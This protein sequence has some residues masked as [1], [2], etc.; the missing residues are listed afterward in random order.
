[1]VR[2]ADD[3]G[4]VRAETTHAIRTIT[5]DSPHNANALSTRLIG[6]L[7]AELDD[8]LS[9]PDVRVIV[10]T[11]AGKVFCSGADLKEA[12]ITPAGAAPLMAAVL[13]ALWG[14]P[15]PVSCPANGAARA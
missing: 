8:A 7:K 15:K 1:M 12:S 5:L 2:D 11:G 6:Q 14:S 9:D 4:L 3:A 13:H 10:L